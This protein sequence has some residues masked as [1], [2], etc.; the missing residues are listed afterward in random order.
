VA[1]NLRCGGASK[2]SGTTSAAP[3][4]RQGDLAGGRALPFDAV[5]VNVGE[6]PSTP[7]G[8]MVVQQGVVRQPAG[9]TLV[10][11]APAASRRPTSTSRRA[12]ATLPRN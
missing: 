10:D 5:P 9:G 1:R 12:S 8:R 4:W 3:A 2:P 11:A 7:S 6:A